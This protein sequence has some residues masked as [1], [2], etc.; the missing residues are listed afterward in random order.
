MELDITHPL[1]GEVEPVYKKKVWATFDWFC[2]PPE[3]R[4]KDDQNP[5]EFL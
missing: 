1:G 2:G 5:P 4:P 3:N